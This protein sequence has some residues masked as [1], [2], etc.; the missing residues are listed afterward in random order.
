MKICAGFFS[1]WFIR[2]LASCEANEYASRDVHTQ[3]V[4]A[5]QTHQS[6]RP[7]LFRNLCRSFRTSGFSSSLVGKMSSNQETMVNNTKSYSPSCS[8]NSENRVTTVHNGSATSCQFTFIYCR[9]GA[10]EGTS[11]YNLQTFPRDARSLGF[12][13]LQTRRVFSG[14]TLDF[15]QETWQKWSC[16][17]FHLHL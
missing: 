9:W 10:S 1:S 8:N 4:A 13:V 15:T 14:F 3:S 6:T 2:L 17:S 7:G 12:I 16:E 11:S 5:G